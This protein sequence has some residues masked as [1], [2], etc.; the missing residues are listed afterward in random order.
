MNKALPFILNFL[1]RFYITG[2]HHAIHRLQEPEC[3]EDKAHISIHLRLIIVY[4]VDIA[5][6]NLVIALTDNGDKNVHD[7]N[8]ND[9]LV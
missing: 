5:S 2:H 3:F 8:E 7:Y 1:L 4:M 6:F 9:P